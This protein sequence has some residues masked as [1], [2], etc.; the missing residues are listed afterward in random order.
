MGCPCFLHTLRCRSSAGRNPSQREVEWTEVRSPRYGECLCWGLL[1][2]YLVGRSSYKSNLRFPAAQNQQKPK[3]ALSECPMA[4]DGMC[5][6]STSARWK[7]GCTLLQR[8]LCVPCGM[9]NGKVFF[10]A[11]L[12]GCGHQV[13]DQPSLERSRLANL[14]DL[15][16]QGHEGNNP[17]QKSVVLIA[18]KTNYKC[19]NNTSHS[20]PFT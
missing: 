5:W 13:K 17:I 19:L 18:S 11:S 1:K 12:P 14:P 2:A 7:A 9:W 15:C 8:S 3:Q 10:R 20:R 6:C 16:F 4:G